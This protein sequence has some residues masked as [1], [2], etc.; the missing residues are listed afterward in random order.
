MK[1][2][3]P[4]ELNPQIATLQ[5]K[6]NVLQIEKKAKVAEASIVR[7][8]IQDSPSNGNAA[9]N[10]VR[11]ILGQTPIPETAPDMPRLEELLL[12]LN[13]LNRAIGILDGAIRQEMAKAS[14]MVCEQARPEV[15]RLGREFA[16]AFANLHSAHSAYL[17]V[18][19]AIEDTGANPSSL[20]K[21]W[22]NGLGHVADRSGT[23]FYSFKEFLEAGLIEQSAIP[24]AV[25]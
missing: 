24:E 23:Y 13:D 22:P 12:E 4:T 11:V 1:I 5:N 17:Q 6:L 8:R 9:E 18:F 16:Q 21:V 3:T 7:A 14:K 15:T 20:P 2:P 19:D 25:R 10:R